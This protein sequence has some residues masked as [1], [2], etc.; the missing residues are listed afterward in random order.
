MGR[1]GEKKKKEEKN[2]KNTGKLKTQKFV[3]IVVTYGEQN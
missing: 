3:C 2:T 1:E